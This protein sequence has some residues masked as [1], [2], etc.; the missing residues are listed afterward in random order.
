AGSDADD[1]GRSGGVSS[2]GVSNVAAGSDADDG[3]RSGGVSSGGASASV[4]YLDSLIKKYDALTLSYEMAGGYEYRSRIRGVMKGLEIGGSDIGNDTP[5]STLSSGQKARLS[6]A[7]TLINLPDILLLDEP[8]NHLD[9]DSLKWLEDYLRNYK[10]CFVVISHDRYFLDNVTSKIIEIEN[11]S[12]VTYN[13]NYS[14]YLRK[15]AEDRELQMR[16]YE[17]QQKEISRLESFIKQQRQWNRERNIIAAES[18]QKAIDRIDRIEKPKDIPRKI[19]IRF[20]KAATGGNDV[21][22]ID[23]VSKGF[24]NRLLFSGFSSV[25][26]RND[27]VF[28]IGPNGCGK[29]TLLSIIAGRLA[30]DSGCAELGY[31]IRLGYHDQEHIDLNDERSVLEEA[32]NEDNGSAI[33][34]VRNLLASLLFYGDDVQ[35]RIKLLSGGEKSRVAL[36]KLIL[37]GANLLLLDEPTN[38]LDIASREALEN[39]LRAFSGTIITVSHDRYFIKNFATRIFYFDGAGV[40]DFMGGYE[41]YLSI[42]EENAAVATRIDS[43]LSDASREGVDWLGNNWLGENRTAVYQPDNIRL[44]TNEQGE[45]RI[46]FDRQSGNMQSYYRQSEKPGK[47]ES[48]NKLEYNRIKEVRSIQNR[49]ATQL[50]RAEDQIEVIERRL[51]EI[52]SE[53]ADEKN[54]SDHEKL[55]VLSGEQDE[56]NVSLEHWLK[57]WE[58]LSNANLETIKDPQ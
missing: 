23:N 25:V 39:S 22:Y 16:R 28:V 53:M 36:A 9:M 19:N 27:R 51:S 55:I 32:L 14:F 12:T 46:G 26:K 34:D 6:L 20:Q 10:K 13:G 24:G 56:L 49:L 48:L 18:R 8:T 44:G 37:S 3:G 17:N 5:I 21:L 47:K 41:D 57:Q 50:K 29:S 35:K 15:K 4:E 1:G 38:H 52:E 33:T 43:S 45:N 30:P 42:A 54:I 31:G 58:H 11:R 2:G 40:V 7:L